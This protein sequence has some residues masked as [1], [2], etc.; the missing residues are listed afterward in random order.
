MLTCNVLLILH[1]S[2]IL[3]NTNFKKTKDLYGGVK[4]KSVFTVVPVILKKNYL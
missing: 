3:C 2:K 4:W 1:I